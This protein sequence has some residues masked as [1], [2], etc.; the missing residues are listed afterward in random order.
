MPLLITAAELR[1]IYDTERDDTELQAFLDT[2]QTFTDDR[3]AGKGLT[4]AVLKQVQ[5]YLAAHFLFVTD[6]GVHAALRVG[7]VNE[8]FT[9]HDKNPGLFDSRWGCMAVVLD[10]SGTLAALARPAPKAELRVMGYR[11]GD[12]RR[13]C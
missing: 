3:L 12:A 5:R 11:C 2:A 10:S 9:S 7:D 6:A 8:R 1:E 13:S 4:D